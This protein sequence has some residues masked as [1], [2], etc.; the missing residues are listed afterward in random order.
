MCKVPLNLNRRQIH[1]ISVAVRQV[2]KD[3]YFVPEEEVHQII[4]KVHA[5]IEES[6][7]P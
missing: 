4:H 6:T 1:A 2:A 7:K 3:R 5:K